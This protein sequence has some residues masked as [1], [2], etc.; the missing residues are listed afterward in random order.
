MC[1]V[2][3]SGALR[4]WG[5]KCVKPF[6]CELAVDHV[7]LVGFIACPP[8]SLSSLLNSALYACMHACMCVCVCACVCSVIEFS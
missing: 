7:G 1:A 5:C 3:V 8:P 6:V 4:P 2:C